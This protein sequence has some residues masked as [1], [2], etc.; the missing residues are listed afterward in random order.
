MFKNLATLTAKTIKT[1]LGRWGVAPDKI[2][3]IYN[4]S[5]V[6]DHSLD[7]HYPNEFCEFHIKEYINYCTIC[8]QMMDSNKLEYKNDKYGYLHKKYCRKLKK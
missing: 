8:H 5:S 4:T 1:P 6:Y 7:T 3:K 2:I